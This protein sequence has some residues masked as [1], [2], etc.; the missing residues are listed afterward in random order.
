MDLIVKP[1]NKLTGIYSTDSLPAIP[2]DKSIS[3]RA[4]LFAGMAEG[5]S[6]ISNFMVSGVTQVLLDALHLF[7]VNYKLSGTDLT[8]ESPGFRSWNTPEIPINCG[9]S[10][11][12]MRLLAG[13][14]AASGIR[15]VLD[16][17]PS[18]RNRP[19]NRIIT[20]L[21]QMGVVIQGND[22]G[23][24]PLMIEARKPGHHLQPINY[25]LPV[26]SAQVKTCILIAA[27]SAPGNNI[28]REP[29]RSRDHT[30]RLLQSMGFN[31][32]NKQITPTDSS[33]IINFS[34]T[35]PSKLVPLSISIPGDFSSAAFLIVSTLITPGSSVQLRGI[36][37]NPTRTGLLTALQQMK[38]QIET[39]NISIE[40]GETL[41]DIEIKHSSLSGIQ[42]AG[43]LVVSM[44]D[45]FPALA[46]AA[47]YA[48][49]ITSVSQAKEL[50]YKE[51][52]R[53]TSLCEELN[54]LG[55]KIIEAPDGFSILSSG[56]VSGGE[57]M[58][59]NDHRLA[60]SLACA[61]LA[62]TGTVTIKNAE[63]IN[64]SFPAF[65]DILTSAGADVTFI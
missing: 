50:R 13:A 24:A 58:P 31:I 65:P 19:M 34:S 22:S 41:G 29:N 32:Q 47:A 3:H 8:I 6:H 54:K 11:T 4:A 37:L 17:T 10:A 26:A 45:E 57:V 49:G 14:V 16:G 52:D 33:N 53:I 43:D 44:I 23:K 30:E 48:H 56:Q 1:G 55:V 2:G 12:T 60:M 59:H 9:N 27:L 62:A 21:S 36:G 20:P 42:I 25:A 38:A 7:G 18:L 28:I 63:I 39:L 61:G 40:Y 15:A 64:E 35:F 46:T 5:K 51:T